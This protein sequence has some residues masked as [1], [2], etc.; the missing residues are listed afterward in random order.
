MIPQSPDSITPTTPVSYEERTTWFHQ[1]RFGLFVHYGL[2]SAPGRGEWLMF[3]ERMPPE[4][5]AQLAQDFVPDADAARQWAQ[6][7]VEAGMKYAVI[8]TRHHDGF[9]LFD[10]PA[11][12]FNL[13]KTA[14]R[15]LVAEFALACREAG[16]RV[17]L[18]YSLIDWRFPGYFEPEIYSESAAA[19]VEEVHAEVRHLMSAYGPIDLLWYDGAWIDHGRKDQ[20]KAT[21]WRAAELNQMVYDLQPRILV[22][23]RS[24]L[25]LDLDTPEQVV[26]ASGRGRAWETC[27]TIGD[28]AGWGW[29]R[30]NPNRKTVATLLQNLVGTAADE[31]N[32][33]INIGPRADGSLDQEDAE[34]LLEVGRWLQTCGEA[35]YGSQG[36]ALYDQNNPGAPLGRWTRQ[37]DVGYLHIFRWPG[38]EA[39]IPLVKT[40]ALAATLLNTGAPVSVSTASN[41]RLI[42]GDLPDEPP[43]PSVNTIRVEFEG[44]PQSLAEEDHAAWLAAPPRERD[45]SV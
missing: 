30:D 43:H 33:L 15:D 32:F 2:Y 24:G 26:K 5:Y 40:R 44:E 13:M 18:Y 27:M 11:N 3:S 22:N 34:R 16:L 29:L 31:G 6:L 21:F 19:L 35:I 20:D 38:R 39:I 17:G 8:T 10:S 28:S 1:A 7:A 36:C 45:A 4:E 14:G 42:L 23:N 9:S 12:N 37:G 25:D 41:G